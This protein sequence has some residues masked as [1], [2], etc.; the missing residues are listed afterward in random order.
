M[1]RH[2][3]ACKLQ[4]LQPGRSQIGLAD[5]RFIASAILI[6]LYSLFILASLYVFM[7]GGFSITRSIFLVLSALTIVALT[8][9]GGKNLRFWAFILCGFL[10]LFG[11]SSLGLSIWQYAVNAPVPTAVLWAGPVLIFVSA[12]TYWVLGTGRQQAPEDPTEL[13]I[14]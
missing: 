5:M 8:G 13:E 10:C 6:V 4:K 14:P 7:M 11:V 9:K 2:T 1:H 12:T 3:L